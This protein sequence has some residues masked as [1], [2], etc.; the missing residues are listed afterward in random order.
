[1]A[2]IDCRARLDQAAGRSLTD[3]EVANIYERIHK[4]ALD[5]KAGRRAPPAGRGGMQGVVDAAAQEAAAKMAADAARQYRNASLTVIKLAARQGDMQ[6]IKAAVGSGIEALSR[7]IAN[8]ADGRANAFSLENHFEGVKRD[9]QR[10]VQDTFLALGDDFFGFLQDTDKIRLLVREM[11]GDNTGDA[12]AKKG[13]DAWRAMTEEFRNRFN[14][15]GGDIGFL[16]DWGMPQ[17]HSQELVARAGK[18]AWVDAIYP[19]LDHARY[20]DDAG[21]AWNEAK[22]RDFLG[23]A[24]DTIATDGYAN[25][26]PGKFKGTG[27][28]ANRGAE[29]R[30]VHFRD[31][32]AYLN[33]WAQFGDKTFMDILMSHTEGLAKN[34]AFV[35][36]FGPNPDLV[37]RSLRDQAAIEQAKAAAASPDAGVRATGPTKVDARLDKLDT[38]WEVASGRTKPI[39]NMAVAKTMDAIRGLNV[40][41]KLGSAFWASL[42]GDKVM[43]ETMNFLNDMP[44][45][46]SWK[47]ELRM[48]NPANEADRLAL[49]RQGLMLDYF[50]TAMTRW[51]DDLGA[52][53]WIDKSAGAVMR[54]SG[55]NA[56]NEWRRGAFSLT[57]MD[58]LG[59]LVRDKNF[60]DVQG[61]DMHIMKTYGINDLDWRIWKLARLEDFGHGNDAMLTPDSIMKITDDQL[62]QAN[63]IAQVSEPI[64]GKRVRQQAMTKLLGTIGSESK[65]AIVEPG[66]RER[67]QMKH[68]TGDGPI[69]KAMWQFKSFPIAQF[70]RMWDV[71]MSKPTTGGK[72]AVLAS[73]VT[74]QILA[75]AMIVQTR[76]MLAGKDPRPMD[77]K[78]VLQSFLQGGALGVYGDFIY[79]LNQT[80]Y[81]TGPLELA[82]GPTI[83]AAL[84]LI[85]SSANAARA[86]YEGRDSHFAAHLMNVA[87]GFVPGNNLWFT[88]AA[89][90]HLIFQNIQEQLSPGY[91]ANMRNKTMHEYGQDWWWSPGETTPDRAPDLHGAIPQ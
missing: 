5:I 53:T 85:T 7:L 46:Q 76:D 66:W 25:L 83:G 82:A 47:N 75:G 8:R 55:M 73:I 58:T 14:D 71:S 60:A 87:K 39:A 18:Q 28:R 42:F 38:L 89:F 33:Y 80:R 67:A 81:G 54:V 86:S 68:L 19:A 35:E 43:M 64:E 16:E 15:G 59:R 20:I 4:V 9:M 32:E 49:Q 31:A 79:S 13:G 27:A 36:H 24:W 56:I 51:G 40:A 72:A 2:Y 1:M 11:R 22:I 78:F 23:H 63:I 26:E 69:A 52:S 30:A 21:V 12:L 62:R 65:T 10:R 29:E 50:R 77:W 6:A 91:L 88:K 84:D 34:I 90:D 44:M 41:G 70:E 3:Q 37:Y 45:M 17:H 57:L 48:L 61:N 74:M